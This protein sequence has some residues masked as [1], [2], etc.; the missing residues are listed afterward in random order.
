MDG[1]KRRPRSLTVFTRE[2]GGEPNA[3]DASLPA[4]CQATPRDSTPPRRWFGLSPDRLDQPAVYPTRRERADLVLGQA[5]MVT[6][7]VSTFAISPIGVR[8]AD[9]VVT[10]DRRWRRFDRA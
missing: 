5:Q 10:A 9:L 4:R 6:A 1:A 3:R 7:S 8:L 2:P